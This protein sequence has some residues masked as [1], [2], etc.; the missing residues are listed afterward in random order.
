MTEIT[1]KPC[2]FPSCGSSDAFAFNM[3]KGTGYCHVC[4]GTYPS[5]KPQF[6]WARQEYPPKERALGKARWNT[7]DNNSKE[8]DFWEAYEMS[9]TDVETTVVDEEPYVPVG[10]LKVAQVPRRG[11]MGKTLAHFKTKVYTDG[12]DVPVKDEY[13]YSSGGVKTRHIHGKGFSITGNVNSLFGMDL[14]PPSSSRVVTV[15]EGEIDCMSSW[16]M[17]SAGNNFVNPVVSVPSAT[18]S[19]KMWEDC[20]DYLDSF[21]KIILSV[22]TDKAGDKLAENMSKMFLGKVYRINHGIYKDANDFL[23]AGEG[24]AYKSAWWA[25]KK[26]KPDKF[27]SSPD[28]WA[29]ALVEETPYEYVPTPIAALNSKIKGFVKGGITVI[30]ALPGTGKTT[31]FRYFQHH[32]IKHSDARVAVLHMEEMTSTTGRGLVT[33]D[34]GINVS[35]KED[36]ADNGVSEEQ[37]IDCLR[38]LVEDDRFITFSVD[39]ENAIEDTIEKI[40]IARAVYNVDYVFLDHLQRL[41]YL[42]GV[43][44]AT[45][46]LTS[47]AVKIVDMTRTDAFSVIAI[48][49]VNNDG[50]TKYARAVEEEA[51]VVLELSRDPK[52]EDPGERDTTYISVMK[53]RPFALTG[54]AGCLEYDHKTTMVKE[55]VKGEGQTYAAHKQAKEKGA[56]SRDIW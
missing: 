8:D 7:K 47:L 53:N 48:S 28:D 35:T 5:R 37:V 40:R 22:D 26:V 52:A 24:K 38:G 15:C 41:A 13:L 42:G 49:H 43:D 19:R 39:P 1:H 31:T 32:L 10:P 54:D 18:P 50:A 55:K 17:L 9:S 20:R 45:A 44:N 3:D 46:G 51:I 29:K 25:A 23:Q 6:D 56:P 21:D 30:K 33:Y 27:V 11:I 12:D 4:A 2:P 36:A 16:Q 14:F 34:M